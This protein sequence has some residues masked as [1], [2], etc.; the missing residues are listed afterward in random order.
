MVFSE[1][2]ELRVFVVRFLCF[3]Q[4]DNEALRVYHHTVKESKLDRLIV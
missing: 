2:R 4:L 3:R 1:F